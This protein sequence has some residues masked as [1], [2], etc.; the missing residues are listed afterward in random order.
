VDSPCYA[1]SS[2]RFLKLFPANETTITERIA[3]F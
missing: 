2:K 1:L 3:R